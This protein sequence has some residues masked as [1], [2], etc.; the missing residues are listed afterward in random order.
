M[1]LAILFPVTLGTMLL[2]SYV[3]PFF[4]LLIF[5][6]LTIFGYY[7]VSLKCPSCQTPI[8]LKFGTNG[9]YWS[10]GVPARCRVCNNA[11]A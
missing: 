1:A 4:E 9:I 11:L 5:L 6:W 3:H 7:F 2:T 10:P 8:L